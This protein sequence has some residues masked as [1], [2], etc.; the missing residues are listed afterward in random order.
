MGRF[1]DRFSLSVYRPIFQNHWGTRT[2]RK[3]LAPTPWHLTLVL[4]NCGGGVKI[5][6]SM[7]LAKSK[8]L[9][10]KGAT[11]TEKI[12]LPNFREQR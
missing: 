4:E 12:E 9:C 6:L 3:S 10:M 8:L 5:T 2:I 1:F 11:Q 7:S